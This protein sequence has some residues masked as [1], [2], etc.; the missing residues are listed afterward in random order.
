MNV[1]ST[2]ELA[3][4]LSVTKKEPDGYLAATCTGQIFI[5]LT[6]KKKSLV[7]FSHVS[8]MRK[9]YDCEKIILSRYFVGFR[10]FQHH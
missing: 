5:L 1:P 4:D 2:E 8:N 10:N 3:I 6:G 9:Y 7:L